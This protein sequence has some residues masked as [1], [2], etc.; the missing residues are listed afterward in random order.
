MLFVSCLRKFAKPKITEIFLLC[1]LLG[2]S[3]FL[4]LYLSLA[5]IWSYFL[6]KRIGVLPSFLPLLFSF[7]FPSFSSLPSFLYPLLPFSLEYRYSISISK[8]YFLFSV[9]QEFV[10]L[11]EVGICQVLFLYLLNMIRWFFLF[12]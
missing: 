5:S 4:L 6:L 12:P 9:L 8:S 7:F 2:F 11:M 10:S 1:V 3:S